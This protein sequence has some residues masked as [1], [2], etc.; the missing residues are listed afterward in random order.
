MGRDGKAWDVS[1]C[2]TGVTRLSPGFAAEGRPI[3]SGDPKVSYGSG[4]ADVD[5]GL[6]AA[7]LSESFHRR[8]LLTERTLAILE[9]PDGRGINVRAAHNLL[10]PSHL[11]LH[12]KQGNQLMLKRAL[13]FYLSKQEHN[14]DYVSPKEGDLYDRFLYHIAE[15]YGNFAARLEDEYIFCWLDWDG[16][17][18]LLAGGIIDYGSIRQF[19][20]CHHRYRYDD[21]D[22]FST[23]LR[24]QKAKARYLV[25]I[26]AQLVDFV[27]TGQKKH[28]RCFRDHPA[29]AAFDKSY[30]ATN[31]EA[32][33]KRLGLSPRQ[34]QLCMSQKKELVNNLEKAF[35][36]FERK[37]SPRGLRKVADGVNQPAIFDARALLLELPKALLNKGSALETKEFLALMKTPFLTRKEMGNSAA[38]AVRVVRFQRFYLELLAF[39][40]EN[41]PFKRSLL[42][43][44]MRASQHNPQGRV[45]GD[46]IIHVVNHLLFKRKKIS[47]NEF[48]ALIDAF[49]RL[50][51]G[52]PVKHRLQKETKRLLAKLLSI[53]EENQFSI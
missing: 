40:G 34:R 25:Q 6:T 3:R 31:T 53:V 12:L 36:F 18:M 46:G 33:L 27:R 28:H 47:R 11:F 4:L 38:Y 44:A 24:E 14:R 41:R 51:Q 20:L 13:D 49:V 7:I 39:A 52:L 32:F 50:Q 30:N 29:L 8:G 26:Y 17:N 43:A 42:E 35:R 23:N 2:G 1:S 10:R 48:Q 15:R 37:E 5:E 9:G 22:R 16:D 19:G 45:T 21:V